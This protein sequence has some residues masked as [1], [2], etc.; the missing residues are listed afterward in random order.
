MTDFF[1]TEAG[2]CAMVAKQFMEAALILEDTNLDARRRKIIFRPTLHLAGQGL[3]LILKACIL[4]NGGKPPTSG[5]AGHDINGL[6]NDAKSEPV[7]RLAFSKA[8]R[9]AEQDRASGDYPDVPPKDEILP[10]FKQAILRLGELH[11][12][13]PYAL[14]YYS[15]PDPLAPRTPLL[16]KTLWH[17][18]ED[19]VRNPRDFELSKFGS[20]A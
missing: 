20:G 15:E 18:S 10:M 2:K 5:K 14:R 8:A 12:G 7:R 3:E 19:F 1:D 9:V 4:W 16:V 11:G 17:V 13:Q 6:W